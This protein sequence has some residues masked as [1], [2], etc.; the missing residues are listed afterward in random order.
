MVVGYRDGVPI[1]PVVLADAKTCKDT[2]GDVFHRALLM[3]A[4]L[5]SFASV[6]PC[7]SDLPDDAQT[8]AT[9]APPHK[10]TKHVFGVVPNF[11][12]APSSAAGEP[13]TPREKFGI[14]AQDSFD[15]GTILGVPDSARVLCAH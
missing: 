13:V 5:T 10:E 14:A 8:G 11:R 12:T 7:Q 6:S 3:A 4:S 1:V 2:E 9:E 15:R